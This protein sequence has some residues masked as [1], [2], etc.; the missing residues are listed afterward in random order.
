MHGKKVYKYAV[1]SIKD[2]LEGLLD[3]ADI[4]LPDIDRFIFHQANHRILNTAA[5]KIG[6]PPEKILFTI[7]KYGNLSVT[8]I[9]HT[10]DDALREGSIQD[11]DL[12]YFHGFGAG[13]KSD[14]AA[15]IYHENP[16]L[17]EI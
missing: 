3:D 6:I 8:S 1:E 10:F 16:K 17:V 15:F 5:G 7:Q 4:K 11:G 9:P 2:S 14:A 12:V 13:W